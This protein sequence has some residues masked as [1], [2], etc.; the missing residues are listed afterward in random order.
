MECW[1]SS[2]V[3]FKSICN[4][5]SNYEDS[6]CSIISKGRECFI[7]VYEVSKSQKRKGAWIPYIL[8]EKK[9]SSIHKY[10][11]II[12]YERLHL[13]NV[14]I[15]WELLMWLLMCHM[16]LKRVQICFLCA[17]SVK[18]ATNACYRFNNKP[19]VTIITFSSAA[20]LINVNVTFNQYS[21]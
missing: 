20:C 18:K 1:N 2:L 4:I 13:Y 6:T 17:K 8:G 5:I 12:W 9:A 10:N 19:E 16:N 14:K 7:V 3:C 11:M 15:K 21:N